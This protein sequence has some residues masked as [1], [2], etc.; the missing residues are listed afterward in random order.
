MDHASL[1][2]NDLLESTLTYM[3]RYQQFVCSSVLFVCALFVSV[4]V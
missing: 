4:D 2:N 3:L 1:A